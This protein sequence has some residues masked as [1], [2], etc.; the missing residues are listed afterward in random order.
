VREICAG[1][2][3]SGIKVGHWTHPDI[4]TGVTVVV[5]SVR[6]VCAVDVSGGSPATRETD[7]LASWRRVDRVDAIVFSGGSAYGL[8]AA[9]SV[10]LALAAQGQG[11]R[12]SYGFVP[13]V[14]A[15][16]I[17][18]LFFAGVDEN[19]VPRHPPVDAGKAAFAAA[20]SSPEWGCVGAG[21]GATVGKT[22]GFRSAMK[23]GIGAA[24]LLFDGQNFAADSACAEVNGGHDLA[25]GA[26]A[27]VNPVGDVVE[28]DG[29]VIA[30]CRASSY[31]QAKASWDSFR[32]QERENTTLV[33]VTTNAVLD[34]AACYALARTAQ[35]GI[36]RA[37]RPA[38][39]RYDGDVVFAL[40]TAD[41]SRT[42]GFSHKL[43]DKA[44]NESADRLVSQVPDVVG[45]A[46]RHAVRSATS[47]ESMPS[48]H[49]QKK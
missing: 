19:S 38:H 21:A 34:A 48:V 18:D 17:Y 39:T 24:A 46:V 32:S 26:I 22:L 12:T 6:G 7:L 8:G 37:V 9:H 44:V 11:H 42:D 33:V 31:I 43:V 49:L 29:A 1:V 28:D 30:G 23:S 5:P 3:T 36:G 25:L 2:L 10:M 45:A 16:C 35:D 4:S 27:V 41:L 13:I 20:T 47:V 40:S 15:A 14:P